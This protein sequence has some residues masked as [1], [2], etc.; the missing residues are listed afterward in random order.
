MRDQIQRSGA[1]CDAVGPIGGS[2]PLAK[3]PHR[4]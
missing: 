3:A 4:P 1:R 2:S